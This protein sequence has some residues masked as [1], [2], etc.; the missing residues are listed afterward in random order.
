MKIPTRPS[1]QSGFTLMEILVVVAI[2]VVLA[3]IA[4][5]VIGRLKANAHKNDALGIMKNLSAAVGQHAAQYDGRLPD[6]D[7]KGSDDWKEA[8]SPES[9]KA[10][11]NALPRLMGAK[12]VG[13]FAAEKREAAF[14]TKESVLFL[15]GASYPEGKKMGRP[16]FA[17]AMNG[18]LMRKDKDGK[19]PNIRL[20]NIA[21]PGRTVI[22]LEQGLPGEPSAHETISKKDYDG[23]PK[24][25]AKSFVARYTG[26]GIIAFLDGH[27]EEVAGKDLLQPNGDM[28][29]SE[30][31][32]ATDP[33]AILWTADP[34][35]D[36][37]S[38]MNQ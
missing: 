1:R 2:I 27:A 37:N 24:G 29:W 13:D 20:Q 3:A 25:N 22:F 33:S 16:Y 15:P 31:Q 30:E 34:K 35:E 11:Y 23:A 5:P 6:E 4:V 18:R 9:S 21:M 10:W 12:G 8:A 17:I 28:I 32:A 14:Y 38:K 26:K 19:K 36:P 7:V